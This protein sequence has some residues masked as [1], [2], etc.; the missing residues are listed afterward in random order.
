MKYLAPC[1]LFLFNNPI[2]TLLGLSV[3]AV[4]ACGAIFE[5]RMNYR[6]E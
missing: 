6:K 1:V 5:A 4:L 3:I 2:L